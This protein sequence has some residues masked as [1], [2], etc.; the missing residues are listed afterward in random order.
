MMERTRP[1]PPLLIRSI[2]P[3]V[4]VALY[5]PLV[6]MVVGSFTEPT[7]GAASHLSLRWYGE[8]F[9][10]PVLW[11]SL[12]RSLIVAFGSATLSTVLGSLGALALDKWIFPGRSPLRGLSV[13]SLMLPELVLALSLLT[14]FALWGISLSLGTV[15]VAH[16]TLT[17]PFVILVIGARLKG[18]DPSYDDAARDLGASESQILLKVTV[19][20]LAPSIL[21]A[22]LLAFLLSFDDFLITFYT[23]GSG[24]DTLP[25]RL[26]SLMKTGLSPKIQALSS[27]MLFVSVA[28]IVILVRLRGLKALSE[29]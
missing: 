23:N 7:P 11:G 25:V 4:L 2:L 29:G 24:S 27:I 10:D 14:W 3:I 21:T 9:Q 26:Y 6:V 17:L 18:L 20:L 5:I 1:Q 13:L 16:V 12:V 8:V 15:I 28:L 19:P 22:F